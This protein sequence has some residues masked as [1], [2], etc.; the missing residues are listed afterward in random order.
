[1]VLA[2]KIEDKYSKND[3]L[4][5]YLNNVYFGH[6]AYGINTASLTY[7][8]HSIKEATLYEVATLVGITNNPTLFDPVNQPENSLKRTKIILSEMV[9]QGYISEKIRKMLLLI[10]VKLN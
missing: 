8:G 4:E 10:L 1:M 9:K 7:F 6:G 2:Q 3:I 5:F